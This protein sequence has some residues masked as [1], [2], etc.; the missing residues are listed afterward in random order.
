MSLFKKSVN[1]L[2]AQLGSISSNVLIKLFSCYCCSF[3]GI[4]LCN[5]ES[6]MMSKICA[7]L[8][9]NYRT[10]NRYIALLANCNNLENQ[11]KL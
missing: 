4:A 7:L 1:M 8:R 2:M 6:S 11:I 5:L 3:Y 10:H 9:L